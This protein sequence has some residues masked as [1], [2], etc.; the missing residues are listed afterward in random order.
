MCVV[1]WVWLAESIAPVDREISLKY[2]FWAAVLNVDCGFDLAL[3]LMWSR[4]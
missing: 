4:G 3:M 2:F 1:Q